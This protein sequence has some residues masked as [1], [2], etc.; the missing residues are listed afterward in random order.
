M[1]LPLIVEYTLGRLLTASK[2]YDRGLLI[3]HPV[4]KGI[5]EAI[6]VTCDIGPSG[7]SFHIEHTGLNPEGKNNAFPKIS[8]KPAESIKNEVKEYLM[9]V[10]DPD[11]P[12]PPSLFE[13]IHGIFY[14]ISPTKTSIIEEDL[15]TDDG[16]SRESGE[17]VRWTKGGFRIGSVI[18]GLTYG[19]PRP[20][21]GHGEHRYI[22]EVVALKAPAE[23]G[24]MSPMATKAELL[25]ELEGKVLGYGV[26]E[27]VYE[28]KWH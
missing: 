9:L 28:H 27:G 17:G 8:W 14:G 18:R 15:V 20:V 1:G 12:I 26:W 3:N 23:L 16:R 5:P 25:K 11:S 21:C 2:R 13:A 10:E 24:S 4:L 7:S 6:E 19:G 22:Y